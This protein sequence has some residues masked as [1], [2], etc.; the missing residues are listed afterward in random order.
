M[1]PQRAFFVPPALLFFK[2]FFWPHQGLWLGLGVGGADAL[3]DKPYVCY[4]SCKLSFDWL[5]KVTGIKESVSQWEPR[6]GRNILLFKN[7]GCVHIQLHTR[8][9]CQM[10]SCSSTG[11]RGIHFWLPGGG[12]TWVRYSVHPLRVH[13][14]GG[15]IYACVWLWHMVC[16]KQQTTV[17]MSMS[18]RSIPSWDLWGQEA[19]VQISPA[20]TDVSVPL[21]PFSN[22]CR[23]LF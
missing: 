10:Q 16:N 14:W 21:L 3:G 7:G 6:S 15:P 2:L 18:Q 4:V 13:G 8:T 17:T 9:P 20:T 5:K 23:L 1:Q 12:K 19:G 11:D 22:I